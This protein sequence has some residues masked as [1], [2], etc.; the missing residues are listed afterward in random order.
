MN[1]KTIAITKEQYQEIIDT[2]NHGFSGARP[3]N[4]IATALMIEANLGLRIGDILNLRLCDI[5]KDGKRYRLN[6]SE[7]KTDK[8]RYFTVPTEIYDFLKEYTLKND[9]KSDEIIFPITERAVQNHLEKVCDYL[10]WEKLNISTH[11]FRKYYATEI[12]EESG[13]NIVL[14]Q[15]LLQHSSPTITQRYIGIG[16]K[17]LESAIKGHLC[18][19]W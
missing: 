10:G 12:Y 18:L 14:V 13:Y 2:M 6:I 16:S 9:I 1:K 11:S 19:A 17:A 4:R 8:G 15:E 3:N 5:V 7:E